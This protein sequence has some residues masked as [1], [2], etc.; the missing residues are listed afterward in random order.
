MGP[1]G[2]PTP[3]GATA[4]TPSVDSRS[5][6][7]PAGENPASPGQSP[8]APARRPCSGGSAATANPTPHVGS[9]LSHTWH[10]AA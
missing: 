2:A 7:I 1:A 3:A 9:H 8:G 4:A 10:T 5:P 6:S